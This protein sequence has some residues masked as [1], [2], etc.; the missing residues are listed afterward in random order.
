VAL[1][2]SGQGVRVLMR[3]ILVELLCSEQHLL[4]RQPTIEIAFLSVSLCVG[5]NTDWSVLCE[6][7]EHNT[8]QTVL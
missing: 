5:Y 6:C 3:V 2:F 8:R 1:V 4:R 7:N